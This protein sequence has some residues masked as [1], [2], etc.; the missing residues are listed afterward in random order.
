[1]PAAESS[2]LAF[3]EMRSRRPEGDPFEHAENAMRVNRAAARRET[4]AF[5]ISNGVG[6]SVSP[7]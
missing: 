5:T 2:V 3:A 6:S 4:K 7:A 1:V